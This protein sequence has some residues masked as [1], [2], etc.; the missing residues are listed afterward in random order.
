M[1]GVPWNAME[2]HGV[3]WSI[4][5]VPWNSTPW[6]MDGVPWNVMKF[7]GV[8]CHAIPWNVCPWSSIKFHAVCMSIHRNSLNQAT[9]QLDNH[10]LKSALFIGQKNRNN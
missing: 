1:D 4:D 2:F 10:T 5:G 3:P 9:H 8:S 7:H 6:S